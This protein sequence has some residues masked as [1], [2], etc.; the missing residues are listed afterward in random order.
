FNFPFLPYIGVRQLGFCP[1][2]QAPTAA[3]VPRNDLECWCAATFAIWSHSFSGM[4]GFPLVT[5]SRGT[6]RQ[7]KSFQDALTGQ[8]DIHNKKEGLQT[9]HELTNEWAGV[10]DA[11]ESG[12]DLCRA[13]QLLG[14]MY[15][16]GMLTR[17]EMDQEFSRV[18]RVIQRSF[19][20]WEKLVESYL[21]GFGAWIARTGGNVEGEVAFRRGIYERLKRQGFSAYSIPWNT[22][23]S[24]LPGVSGGERTFTKQLLKNYRDDF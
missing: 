9:V 11:R 22:D 1:G 2:S 5:G 13:T 6:R 21:E 24:W 15:L 17:D 23:L 8:W 19:T 18:G 4:E 12:W 10:L 7:I 16:V 3:A 14:M 20:S